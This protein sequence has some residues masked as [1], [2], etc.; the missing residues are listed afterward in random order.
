MHAP[1]SIKD[2]PLWAFTLL[3]VTLGI[4]NT[5]LVHS[6][7][8]MFY[9]MIALCSCPPLIARA[10]KFLRVSVPSLFRVIMAFLVLW[11]TLAVGDQAELYGL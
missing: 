4:L 9:L 5:L 2:A 8:G 3:F 1:Y 6:I 7:P 10:R 11:A